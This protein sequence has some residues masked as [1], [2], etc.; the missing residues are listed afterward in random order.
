MS[1]ILKNHF[2]LSDSMPRY[3]FH[4]YSEVG[5]KLEG[6]HKLVHNSSKN[7]FLLS[8]H[9]LN[10]LT[11]F[12]FILSLEFEIHFFEVFLIKVNHKFFVT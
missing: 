4:F 8:R 3:Q 11:S 9:D 1:S 10:S 5:R 2:K 12:S 6:F 7:N